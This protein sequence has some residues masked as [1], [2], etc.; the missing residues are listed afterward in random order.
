MIKPALYGLNN[1]N[2]DFSHKEA[3]G[4]NQFNSSFPVALCCY[5]HDR[6]I[7]ANYLAIANGELTVAEISINQ[8][9]NSNPNDT[10]VYFAFEASHSPYQKYVVGKLPRTDLVLQNN[11]N[12]IACFEIKLTALP[13]N[14]TCEWSEDKYGSEIVIRPDTIVYLACSL[15][16][17]LGDKLNS[18]LETIFI[19]DWSDERQVLQYI[20]GIVDSIFRISKVLEKDQKSFLI[21]PI[22]KTK[23]KSPELAE[24]CLDV[25]VWSDAGFAN[26]IASIAYKG[27]NEKYTTI[28]RQIRTV[29]WLYRMLL[30][31]KEAGKF[32]PKKIIDELTYNTKNDKAFASSGNITN[33]YMQCDRLVKPIIQKSEIKN[34][35]LGEGQNL[36]SPERRFDAILFNSPGLFL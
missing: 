24:N 10:S 27:E 22:W 19:D 2:R 29:V 30:E 33:Q 5:L 9:F 11:G 12:C 4:K 13:D 7:P 6:N 23:G 28:T 34:L 31:I 8:V 1:T 15:A 25:F 32:N 21:Q 20:D 3:W 17:G 35:V 26:F 16:L 18:T 14:V 36:L